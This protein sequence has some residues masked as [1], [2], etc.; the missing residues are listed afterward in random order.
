[1]SPEIKKFIK[2]FWFSYLGA[3]LLF[4]LVLLLVNLGVFGKMPDWQEL[5]NPKSALATEVISEDG[6]VLGRYYLD[7]NRTNAS[8]NE[9]NANVLNALKATEDERFEEH[10]GIDV[11]ALIKCD[12]IV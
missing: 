3:V 7:E 8:L 10:S 2:Y 12:N 1:M 5:E 11:K 4:G 9:L 6:K